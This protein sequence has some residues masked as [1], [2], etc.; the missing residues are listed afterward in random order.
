M[1]SKSHLP[2]IAFVGFVG[3]GKSTIMRHISS[4]FTLEGFNVKTTAVTI[5]MRISKSLFPF[6]IKFFNSS[7]ILIFQIDRILQIL[8]L[9]LNTFITLPLSAFFKVSLWRKFNRLVLV[10]EFFFGS[11]TNYIHVSRI[12]KIKGFP[13][14]FLLDF[15]FRIIS[16]HLTDTIIIFLSADY[17]TLYRHWCIRKTCTEHTSYLES[18][19]IA[20]NILMK[21]TN[22]HLI[23]L[24]SSNKTV[25]ETITE[26]KP[27]LS[28]AL[29]RYGVRCDLNKK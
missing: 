2:I 19:R 1:P 18:Q 6:L 27:L 12:S 28:K 5:D 24:D 10:E 20:L 16:K 9:S 22:P 26:L 21:L 4:M 15:L 11:I 17:T 29:N 8:D 25:T 23:F 14:N 13:I 7:K 3:A